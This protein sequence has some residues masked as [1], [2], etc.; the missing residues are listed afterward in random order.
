MPS[1][2]YLATTA[3]QRLH[4]AFA[5]SSNR[6]YNSMFRIYLA[7]TIF[8]AW[9]VHKVNVYVLLSFLE[10]LYYNNVSVSPIA[11]YLAA[12]K[13]KCTIFN[14]DVTP[15]GD[16]RIKYYTK[17]ITIN[18]PLQVKLKKI[19]DIPLMLQLIKRCDSTYMGQVFKAIYLLSFFSFLRLSNLVPHAASAFNPLKHL[20][21]AD[22]MFYQQTAVILVKWSKTMQSNN[23]V[24]LLT[25][26]KLS[27]SVLC[28]VT[29]IRNLLAI[30][31]SARNRPLFQ[32]KLGTNWIPL[33]DTRV[34][35]HL[36]DVL[37][38]LHMHHASLTFHAFRC[39]GATFAFNH[40][41]SIQDIQR[42]G[43]WMSDCVWRYIADATNAGSKEA[44][45]FRTALQ[46]TTTY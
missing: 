44:D 15:F 28:P 3:V 43:T 13:A 27:G 33:T 29:A 21:Q 1:Q 30:T 42:H 22:V 20:A 26:P 18:R 45:T 24:R 16:T 37:K 41:T 36:A 32:Y 9:P 25:I 2:K 35:R 19:F 4:S 11:N 31:P 10:F 34:R 46:D 39:S 6:A 23:T 12:I 7:F 14:L 8:M 38:Q 40:D 5:A 17:A